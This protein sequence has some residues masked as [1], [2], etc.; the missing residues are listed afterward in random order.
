MLANWVHSS[1]RVHLEEVAKQLRT[2]G[3]LWLVLDG[4]LPMGR[5]CLRANSKCSFHKNTLRK[6][7]ESRKFEDAL[8]LSTP[9]T[10]P[11]DP[12]LG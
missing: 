11:D 3:K 1:R 2:T 9:R 6:P 10:S 4:G 8:G 7:D 12:A 5:Q